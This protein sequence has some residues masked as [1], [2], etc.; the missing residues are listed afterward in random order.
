[1]NLMKKALQV[2]HQDV[3]DVLILVR[4]LVEILA[5][6]IWHIHLPLVREVLAKVH[7]LLPVRQV[8]TEGV[9]MGAGNIKSKY[10][11]C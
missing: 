10:L 11:S 6:P 9:S 8:A 4:Q 2:H 1:M 5:E 3:K 7:A